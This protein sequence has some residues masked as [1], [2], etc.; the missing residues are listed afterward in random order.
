M[1]SP[2]RVRELQLDGLARYGGAAGEIRNDCVEGSIGAAEQGAWYAAAD[3][4]VDVLTA[5]SMLC[6][7]LVTKH[8]FADGNKRI[9]WMA[10]VDLLLCEGLRVLATEDDAYD[11][12]MR[13]ANGALDRDGLLAWLREPDRLAV[14]I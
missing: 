1:L 10:M 12:A 2:A 6:F 8:C 4:Q 7:Y 13:V 14:V 5:A 3:G 11:V 9:G